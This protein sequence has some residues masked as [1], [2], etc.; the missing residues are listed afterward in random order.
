MSFFLRK[1]NFTYSLTQVR[2]IF[3]RSDA[4]TQ[5]QRKRD[6]AQKKL[7]KEGLL[8]RV[9]KNEIQR[10][11]SLEELK[12]LLAPFH[13][14]KKT[15]AAQARDNGLEPIA[16]AVWFDRASEVRVCQNL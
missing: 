11:E 1:R 5:L 8:T 10:T 15:L 12:E 16:D 14:K 3:E 4:D 13:T 9:L 6:N 7:E 2:E